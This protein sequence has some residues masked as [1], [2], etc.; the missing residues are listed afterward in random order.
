LINLNVLEFEF[1]KYF[2]ICCECKYVTEH[3]EWADRFGNRCYECYQD[4]LFEKRS[5]AIKKV[6]RRK[7]EEQLR[8][9]VKTD[10]GQVDIAGVRIVWANIR[11]ELLRNGRKLTELAKLLGVSDGLLN[12]MM[13]RDQTIKTA[14]IYKIAEWLMTPFEIFVR[15]PRGTKPLKRKNGIPILIY[16]KRMKKEIAN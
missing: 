15:L 1:D 3:P 5:I 11:I 6:A 2:H 7:R 13:Y 14:T 9:Y 10:I 16:H 4:T 12:Q 8:L